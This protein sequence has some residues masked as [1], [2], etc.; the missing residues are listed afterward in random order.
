ME[1]NN[2]QLSGFVT[3]TFSNANW[4]IP[5]LPWVKGASLVA[6]RSLVEFIWKEN[7]RFPEARAYDGL[8]T[9]WAVHHSLPSI[10]EFGNY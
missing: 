5:F 9:P 2:K 4:H 3:S 10:D 7:K 1:V 6:Y 8:P